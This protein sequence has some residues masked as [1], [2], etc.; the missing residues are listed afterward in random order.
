MWACGCHS[1]TIYVYYRLGGV[2]MR[3]Y[4]ANNGTKVTIL[5]NTLTCVREGFIM[6]FPNVKVTYLSENNFIANN[7]IYKV[8]PVIKCGEIDSFNV[9]EV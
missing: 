7:G 8:Y 3:E 4:T 6:V 2:K 9:A 5:G 1:L